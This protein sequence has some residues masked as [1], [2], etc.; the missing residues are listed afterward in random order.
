MQEIW[1]LGTKIPDQRCQLFQISFVL[2]AVAENDRF[3][4]SLQRNRSFGVSDTTTEGFSKKQHLG[5][6]WRWIRPARFASSASN[7]CIGVRQYA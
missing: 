2:D 6:L 5:G 7:V 4:P 3:P 1:Q